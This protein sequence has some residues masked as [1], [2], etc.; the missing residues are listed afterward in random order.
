MRRRKV[1]NLVGI[2]WLEW[3]IENLFK[4]LVKLDLGYLGQ[5]IG[6]VSSF[7]NS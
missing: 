6:K 1:L 5:I 3:Q 4:D 7:L 2:G